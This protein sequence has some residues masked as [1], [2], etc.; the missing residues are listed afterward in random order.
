MS[1]EQKAFGKYHDIM[2]LVV[3]FFLTSILGGFVG[4]TF[5]NWTWDHQERARLLA[6]ERQSAERVLA[7]VSRLMDK[8]IYRMRL[9]VWRM[10][11]GN[12]EERANA[13]QDYREVFYEWNDSL[14]HNRVL[15]GRYFGEKAESNFSDGIWRDVRNADSV[16][17]ALLRT[18]S[19]E[20]EVRKELAERAENKLELLE[21]SAYNLDRL[22]SEAIQQG[23]V[24]I[25]KDK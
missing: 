12:E 9:I 22:M 17:T 7:D 19:K 13:L 14:N 4:A 16:L 20:V 1:S 11:R 15:I 2:L 21:T 23:N 10:Q 24:G 18:T 25:F 5:S 6:A 3:G 8:R